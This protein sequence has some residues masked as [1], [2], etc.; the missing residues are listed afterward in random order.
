MKRSSI[1]TMTLILPTNATLRSSLRSLRAEH[2][3]FLTSSSLVFSCGWG[4]AGRLG[5]GPD[6]TELHTP[7]QVL[8][9]QLLPGKPGKVSTSSTCPPIR[10]VA[11]G[12]EHSVFVTE[13]E[14][15]CYACGAG[16][17]GRLGIS[18]G[19]EEVRTRRP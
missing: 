17:G 11:A 15:Y 19:H 16:F 2:S 7:K 13:K 1:A 9:F 14:G 18:E 8:E 5:H 10:A 3:L 4:E 6:V 12:R